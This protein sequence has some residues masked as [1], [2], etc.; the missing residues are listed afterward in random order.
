MPFDAEKR[1]WESLVLQVRERIRAKTNPTCQECC[2]LF[3][4]WWGLRESVL[5][6]P[7]DSSLRTLEET[8]LSLILAHLEEKHGVKDF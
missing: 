8:A 2:D 1:C 4:Q 3:E 5:T 6:H 7:E